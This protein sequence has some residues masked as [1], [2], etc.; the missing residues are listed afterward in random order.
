MAASDKKGMAVGKRVLKLI[1]VFYIWSAFFA[2]QQMN[3][4]ALI[5][6]YLK[7][8]FV[9]TVKKFICGYYH[10]W[11]LPILCGFYLM[12]PITRQLC[13]KGAT[14]RYY[15]ILWAVFQFILPCL[16]DIFH[17]TLLQDR[18]DS[19]GMNIITGYFGY[20]LLGHYL[21]VTE[22]KKEV[23]KVIYI[24]GI[25]AVLCTIFLTV[26]DCRAQNTYVEKWFSPSSLNSLILSVAIL[27]F[28]QYGKWFE[29]VKHK[30]LWKKLSDY[31]FFI[32]MFHVF[33][34]EKWVGVITVEYSFIVFI[35]IMTIF[36]FAVSL[37]GAF[38]ADHIPL[39]RKVVMFH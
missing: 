4:N 2:L 28:F 39:I 13:I 30:F 31:T 23:R 34:L 18:I 3:V 9:A 36:T 29:Q 32:Y 11:F 26:R 12:I 17:L 27:V 1:M 7:E 14:V 38:I 24:M 10:M 19:L 5:G 8:I 16:T 20:F 33:I 25:A 35:P 6:G 21:G 15:L 22:I 37:L